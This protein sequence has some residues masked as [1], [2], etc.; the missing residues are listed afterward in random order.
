MPPA[1][2]PRYSS[3]VTA[4]SHERVVVATKRSV[5]ASTAMSSLSSVS[6]T[7]DFINVKLENLKPDADNSNN[8]SSDNNNNDNG[9]STKQTVT[10]P[11]DDNSSTYPLSIH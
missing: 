10:A 6:S 3:I 5:S 9:S 7:N 11:P 8:N 2:P 1:N 4:T